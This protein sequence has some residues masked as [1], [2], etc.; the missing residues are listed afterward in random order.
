M[1][2]NGVTIT[3][4]ADNRSA[5]GLEAEH[6]LSFWIETPGQKIL[7]DMGQ[8]D[9]MPRNA[10]ALGV[11]I[12]EAKSI[13]LSHGHYDHTGNVGLALGF[14]S[15]ATLHL[16]PQALCRRYSI[17]DTPRPIGMPESEQAA[18][19]ALPETRRRWVTAPVELDAGVWVSGPVPRETAFEDTGGP[20]FLDAGGSE[21][22][23]IPDDLSLGVQTRAGLVVCLGCCHAGIIN[24]LRHLTR[25]TGESR[26][27]A[28]IGGMHLLHASPERLEQTAEALKEYA[29][30]Y[31][32]AC[33][34]SGEQAVSFL[35]ER[36]GSCVQPCYA[37]LK[38]GF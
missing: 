15:S 18:V 25:V 14:A 4:L 3:V 8:G 6:G 29:V 36:L 16:H 7:F 24:T 37:G 12:G 31:L 17:H 9:A 13:V 27:L 30:P 1:N 20:F 22:D 21:T 19:R 33:H 23:L 2:A 38:V 34:C 5:Y 32:Y 35:A 10:E 26:V 28:V 11:D